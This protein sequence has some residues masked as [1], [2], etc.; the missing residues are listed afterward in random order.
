MRYY[1]VPTAPF[2]RVADKTERDTLGTRPL[3]TYRTASKYLMKG[4]E[5]LDALAVSAYGARN[6]ASWYAIADANADNIIA[7]KGDF[8]TIRTLIIPEF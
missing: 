1:N 2:K 3:P 8:S 7:N 5:Q 6:E 4:T